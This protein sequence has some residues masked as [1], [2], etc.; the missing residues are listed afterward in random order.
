MLYTTKVSL[1]YLLV[2]ICNTLLSAYTFIPISAIV[3]FI[4]APFGVIIIGSV[5]FTPS[6][7]IHLLLKITSTGSQITL[8]IRVNF[9]ISNI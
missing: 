1:I 4:P 3:V 5:T 8:F 2:F 7:S 9:D 6:F